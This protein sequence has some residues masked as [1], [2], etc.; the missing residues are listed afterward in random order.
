MA[1]SGRALSASHKSGQAHNYEHFIPLLVFP[2]PL[3]LLALLRYRDRDA[4]LLLLAALMPQRWF[5][6]AFTLWL[7]A[8]GV[9]CSLPAAASKVPS[10]TAAAS[11]SRRWRARFMMRDTNASPQSLAGLSYRLLLPFTM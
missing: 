5:F 10:E 6:D 8:E 2:G 1:A 3:L 4:W 11:A 7:I 9:T